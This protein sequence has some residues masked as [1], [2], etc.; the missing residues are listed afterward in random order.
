MTYAVVAG[1]DSG[2]GEEYYW[3]RIYTGPFVNK[4]KNCPAGK[5]WSK[6]QTTKTYVIMIKTYHDVYEI[7]S[8]RP[9]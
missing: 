4:V 8:F 3:S 6:Y 7:S 1:Y 2:L 9:V 5:D